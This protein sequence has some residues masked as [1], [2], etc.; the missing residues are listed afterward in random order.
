MKNYKEIIIEFEVIGDYIGYLTDTEPT[1]I[2]GLLKAL[3]FQPELESGEHSYF[4]SHK[5]EYLIKARDYLEK[6]DYLRNMDVSDSK[7]KEL[8]E[9]GVWHRRGEKL[10]CE[11]YREYILSG[12]SEICCPVCQQQPQIDISGLFYQNVHI[13]CNCGYLNY[14]Q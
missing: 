8:L 10:A 14:D 4:C 11:I 3:G 2:V 1:A 12:K 7:I 13:H 6:E 9:K 5:E